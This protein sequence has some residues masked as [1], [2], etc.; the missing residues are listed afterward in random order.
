MYICTILIFLTLS[1]NIKAE[2][3]QA[4]DR[5]GG[6]FPQFSALLLLGA[7]PNLLR[8]A[9]TPGWNALKKRRPGIQAHS[10]RDYCALK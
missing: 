10:L 5:A 8:M 6:H 3:A 9:L 1:D 7:V 2:G 4:L